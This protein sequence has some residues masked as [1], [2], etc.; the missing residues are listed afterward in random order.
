VALRLIIVDHD[1][2][3]RLT[4]K[5]LLAEARIEA[6][7]VERRDRGSA[8]ETLSRE[9]FDVA[10]LDYNLP[11]T[12]GITLLRDLRGRGI[13]TPVVA[14]TG[15]GDER[16]AVEMMKAGA[17]D[18]LNK[19]ALTAERLERS[20]RY[21]IAL[22]RAEEERRQL[23]ARE[24]EARQQAQA[25]NRAKDEFLATLSHE[26]RTPLN[27]ILGWARLLGTGHLDPA[28]TKRAIEIIERNTRLQSQL[29]E[30]L[31]DISRIISGKLRLELSTAHTKPIVEAA[32]DSVRPTAE[33]KGL[34]V[35]CDCKID[36]RI[37]CDPA[38]L[39]QVIWN[40]LSNAIK[41]TPEG[42]RIMVSVDREGTFIRIVVADTGVG[43]DDAFL[44]HVFE[45]FSQQ[46]A[47]STRVHGGLG[48]GLAIVRHIVDLHGGTIT[49]D[50]DGEGKGATFTVIVPIAPLRSEHVAVRQTAGEPLRNLPS[51]TG[52]QVLV[53]D[54]EE[55]ARTL[56]CAVL[57]GCGATTIPVPSTRAAL[58]AIQHAVPDV[59]V[60]DIAMPYEDGYEF[61]RR[62]RAMSGEAKNI[63][64]AALTAYATP[65]DRTRALLAGYQ[66]HVPKPVEPS[67]LAVVVAALA[68]RT[69]LRS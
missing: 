47:A 56:V 66:A 54:D 16:I 2:G 8:L 20:V 12:D 26:L 33:A 60:S 13:R 18:Y 48:I 34:E 21:A 31:L 17:A 35:T 46:D 25:A 32:V 11:G 24:Q 43:I 63:P 51:L 69:V 41:F 22:H 4:V 62:V 3:D 27:A 30:D 29:I 38:R 5:R 10:L 64:A 28:H 6:E 19:N 23:L 58:E 40:L 57:E 67:E 36:E 52:L 50:S 59:I 45:R 15:Q 7:L 49:A 39:Q 1:D 44:P 37:V 53:V 61:I 55:D 9:T 65:A 42:G 68:G 14:L